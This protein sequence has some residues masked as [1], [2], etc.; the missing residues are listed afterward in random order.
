MRGVWIMPDQEN[1]RIEE[2]IT[3]PVVA[4]RMNKTTRTIEM[5]MKRGWIPFYRIGRTTLFRWSEI[6]DHL[7]LTCRISRANLRSQA[8]QSQP[9][10]LTKKRLLVATS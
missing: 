2:Y 9:L 6:Q 5:W 8:M 3:K 7:T 10:Q 4:Q 1:Q